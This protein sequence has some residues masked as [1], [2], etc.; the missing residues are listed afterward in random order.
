MEE[1]CVVLSWF[2]GFLVGGGDISGRCQ[3]LLAAGIDPSL[4][5]IL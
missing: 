1:F 2:W 3:S 4:S 5:V